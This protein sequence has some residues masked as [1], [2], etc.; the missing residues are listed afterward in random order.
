MLSFTPAK[1]FPQSKVLCCGIWV[2]FRY[3]G[4]FQIVPFLVSWSICLVKGRSLLLRL[5]PGPSYEPLTF[6]HSQ[7]CHPQAS[8]G[9]VGT[10]LKSIYLG[11]GKKM[12]PFGYFFFHWFN[13]NYSFINDFMISAKPLGVVSWWLSPMPGNPMLFSICSLSR[14][15]SVRKISPPGTFFPSGIRAGAGSAFPNLP[16]A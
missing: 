1:L 8:P 16:P 9:G 3:S 13:Y 12:G 2:T 15:P 11:P 4:E 5:F 10:R 7:T 6:K 14:S